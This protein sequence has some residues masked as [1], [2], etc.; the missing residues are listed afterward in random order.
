MGNLTLLF[1]TG[2][3]GT[4][5]GASFNADLTT[6]LLDYFNVSINSANGQAY[7]ATLT[8]GTS[9]TTTLNLT[10]GLTNPLGDAISGA[11]KFV[12]VNAVYII[13]D[14]ASL[15]SGITAFGGASGNLFQGFLSAAATVTLPK[16]GIFPMAIPT[17][18]TGMVVDATH[19]NIDITNN[20][21]THVATVNV[22]I[23]GTIN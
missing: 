15:S 23:F 11:A 3:K 4:A 7:V 6:T 8:I 19:K 1:A 18:V 21:A 12:H 17:T 14:A 2:Y 13:H 22:A 9:A 16:A 5:T 10:T 20:D